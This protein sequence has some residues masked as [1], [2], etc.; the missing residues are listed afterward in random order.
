MAHNRRVCNLLP[1]VVAVVI[2]ALVFLGVLV[3][4][5]IWGH[6]TLFPSPAQSAAQQQLF[7]WPLIIG[8]IS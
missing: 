8:A 4:L 2:V 1:L 7:Y 3:A 6:Q 5:A